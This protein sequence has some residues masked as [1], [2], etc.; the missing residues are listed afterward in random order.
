[1]AKTK[2]P[3][4]LSNMAQALTVTSPKP[5]T[6][7]DAVL[8]AD[9]EESAQKD[10]DSYGAQIKYAN[11]LIEVFGQNFWRKASPSFKVWQEE[12][13]R[14]DSTLKEKGH[15]NPSQALERLIVRADAICNPKEA[16]PNTKSTLAERQEKA[17][18]EIFKSGRNE[19]K[20]VGLDS[21]EEKAHLLICKI[22]QDVF[23]KTL[24][25]IK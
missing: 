2:T 6:N 24:S 19:E 10:A 1:M 9:R 21:T 23:K 20:K 22:L 14:Y 16:K 4:P 7:Y 8:K 15:K 3:S 25:E 12:R 18:I 5:A 11:K 13:A 17:L